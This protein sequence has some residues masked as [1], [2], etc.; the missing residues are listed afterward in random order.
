MSPRSR[1]SRGRSGAPGDQYFTEQPGVGSRPST[2]T[3]RLP[4]LTLELR[5]DA[6]VFSTT[7]V[8]PGTRILLD[9]LPAPSAWPPGELADVGC[10]Y[11]PIAVTLARRDPSRT[12]V[13][14]EVNERARALCAA[15][16]EDAGVSAR[17][18]TAD[19]GDLPG[20]LRVGMVVSNPPVRIGKPALHDLCR[21]WLTRL[22]PGGEAWWVVHRHLGADSLQSWM[23]AEGWPTRRVRSRNGYRV[24]CSASA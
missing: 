23:T 17:V 4:D 1:P 21:S 13:A 5:T 19:P 16:A 6:G 2:V 15:N 12:V 20:D 3:L 18:R 8:D 9:V 22:E 10:G 24:L 7:R 11:G 14:V